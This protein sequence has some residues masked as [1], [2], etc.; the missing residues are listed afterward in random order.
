MGS[1]SRGPVWGG[2]QVEGKELLSEYGLPYSFLFL[3][4]RATL[5]SCLG[6]WRPYL[7]LL[8]GSLCG[9][10]PAG[11]G[12]KVGTR[13]LDPHLCN[14]APRLRGFTLNDS[15]LLA[16]TSASDPHPDPKCPTPHPSLAVALSPAPLDQLTPWLA[17]SSPRLPRCSSPA[18]LVCVNVTW[19]AQT[20][21]WMASGHPS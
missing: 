15:Q 4:L 2:R 9:G 17:Y 13:A 14:M 16:P 12:K 7:L 20:G 3:R 21:P 11:E 19:V 5:C 6:A 10:C 18:W 1:R 8:P